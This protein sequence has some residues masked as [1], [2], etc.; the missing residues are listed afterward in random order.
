MGYYTNFELTA[1]IGTPIEE[2]NDFSETFKKIT[3]FEYRE[4]LYDDMKW[5]D[6][7]TNMLNISEMYPST[8]FRLHWNG[9]ESEDVGIGYFWNDNVIYEVMTLPEPKLTNLPGFA[10]A[11]P[12]L[13][14]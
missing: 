12:E 6:V 4:Q 14:L 3:G 8:V 13:L 11:Y 1:V 10:D 5:Y 2:L 7:E 9:A